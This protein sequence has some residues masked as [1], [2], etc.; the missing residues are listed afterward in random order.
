MK[1]KKLIVILAA[2]ALIGAACAAVFF[3]K[4]RGDGE[5]SRKEIAPP[6]SYR[7]GGVDVAALPVLNEKISVYRE[8]VRQEA[9]RVE[10]TGE[11]SGASDAV[12]YYYEGLEA[13]GP[14][15]AAYTA[16]MD[17]ADT[18]F[19]IVDDTLAKTAPPDYEVEEG[20][21]HL[22]RDGAEEG[23]VMS[24]QMTWSKEGCTVTAGTL[25][26]EIAEPPA[27]EAMTISEVADYVRSIPPTTLGLEG[28]SMKE[29]NIYVIDG[30][31]LVDGIPCIRLNVCRDDGE[32]ATNEVAGNYFISA[33]KEH[34]YRLD[35]ETGIA[36]EVG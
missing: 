1:R 12:V 11:D 10:E 14:L 6:M 3:L 15:V 7:I 21:V 34:I 16:L 33:D 24:I 32:A 2:V 9:E 20:S 35:V 28:A 19:C 18:G 30:T 23:R 4:G 8:K 25:P 27:P 5:E 26:G 13:P 36:E 31:V 29:Y 22:A 17:T